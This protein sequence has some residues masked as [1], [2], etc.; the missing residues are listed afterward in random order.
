MN[1]API[2]SGRRPVSNRTA[3]SIYHALLSDILDMRR[4]PN[5]RLIEKELLDRFAVSRTPLREALLRLADDGLVVIYPQVGSF[6][7][8]IPLR[9]LVESIRIRQALEVMLVEAAASKAS[10][11]DLKRL[12]DNFDHL[13]QACNAADQQLFHELDNEFHRLIGQIA[14]MKTVSA[15]ISQI[16][17]QIDRY[18]MLTLPQQGRLRRVVSEHAEIIAAM[19]R[20]DPQAAVKAMGTHLGQMIVEVETLQSLD[21]Q[22][23]D[24]DR[25]KT[26]G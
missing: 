3:D 20:R 7:A 4:K 22:N 9:Q 13:D 26:D 15:T 23:F 19:Q 14:D 10:M 25:E 1:K 18:R 16:R 17:L 8:R 12:Q 21:P 11:V 6:I 2:I 24:D 5:D